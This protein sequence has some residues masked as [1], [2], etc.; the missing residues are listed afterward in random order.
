MKKIRSLG[1]T[2]L[3]AMI[4]LVLG[5]LL[6]VSI[7]FALTIKNVSDTMASSNRNLSET[8]GENSS[9]YMAEQSQRHLLE[10][11]R[12]KAEI[13][14]EVFSDFERSVCIVASV[15]EQIY[16]DPERY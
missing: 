11:A 12:D 14:D 8:I 13:A 6:A 2:I 3:R 10:L 15:A 1:T 9:G 4:V 16:S 5:M 7:I